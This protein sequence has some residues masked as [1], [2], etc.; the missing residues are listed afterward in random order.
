[1]EL[2]NDPDIKISTITLTTQL[3]NCQLNLTNVGKYLNIDDQII[4]IK[5]NHTSL[6]VTKGKYATTIYKKAKVKDDTKINK[7]LFY[8]Q[9]SIIVNNNGNHVN[10]KLF[11][12]GSLHLTG[13][14][15]IEEGI[16]VTNII[17]NKLCSLK[18]VYDTVFLTYDI[19]GVLLDKDNLIYSSID[20]QIIGYSKN[21]LYIINKKDYKIDEK[22][23]M[24]ISNKIETQRRR[25]LYN[26][27]G[28][29][30]GYTQIELLKNKNKL[31]KKHNNTFVDEISGLIYSNDT[32]V[33]GKIV[34]YFEDKNEDIQ[35]QNNE[36]SRD[37]LEIDYNCNP[38]VDKGYTLPT[39]PTTNIDLNVNCINVYFNIGY[40][41]NRQRLYEKLIDMNYICKYKPESYSGIKLIYKISMQ[42]NQIFGQCCCSNKCTCKT[43]TFL[44]F[45]SGNVI[46]TG[47]KSYDDI[48]NITANFLKSSF[49]K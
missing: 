8:N 41:I 1:M 31:Y 39:N 16:E 2:N 27:N 7:T 23:K 17:Y 6:S 18:N 42:E 37:F 12:N 15:K 38:F 40:E 22:T 36:V 9:V 48:K 4:G 45:Q 5:Y 20:H 21:D 28:E 32:S 35:I 13:C 3:P 33:I 26:L 46:A 11:S 47:F 44:I 14:K 49:L 43:I 24:F 10:V 25:Y 34:Y 19:N 29:Y 30:I